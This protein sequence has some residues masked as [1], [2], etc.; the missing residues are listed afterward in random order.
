MSL[1]LNIHCF[2]TENLRLQEIN[3]KRM[4]N[5]NLLWLLKVHK[6]K[7]VVRLD[8]I[9]FANFFSFVCGIDEN[10]LVILEELRDLAEV[11]ILWNLFKKTINKS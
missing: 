8:D 6:F 2:F 3:P 1:Q 4:N 11:S 10:S 7:H 9:D 5:L